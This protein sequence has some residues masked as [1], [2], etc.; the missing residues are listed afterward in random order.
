MDVRKVK[1]VEAKGGAH[2]IPGKSF[3]NMFVLEK[4]D[5][6]TLKD[7]IPCLEISPAEEMLQYLGWCSVGELHYPMAT[8]EVQQAFVMEG[9]KRVKVTGIGA[10]LMLLYLEGSGDFE[11]IINSPK[12]WWNSLFKCVSKWSPKLVAGSRLVWLNIH[13]IPLHVWD[14]P[15]FKQIGSLFGRFIDFD[16]GTISRHRLD[17]ARIQVVTTKRGLIDDVINL[18]V[19]GAVFGLWVVEEGGGRRWSPEERVVREEVSSVCSRELGRGIDGCLS[20]EDGSPRGLT[21]VQAGGSI[22][23]PKGQAL[24]G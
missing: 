18:K 10:N 16:E 24:L 9:L 8:V 7:D 15:L 11:V 22:S 19:M 1:Q 13:G 14:E 3:K 4:E 17:V 23:Q 6:P 2:I 21:S 12:E 5:F 20:D